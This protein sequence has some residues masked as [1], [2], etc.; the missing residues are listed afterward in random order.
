[1]TLGAF[2]LVNVFFYSA[3]RLVEIR[4][5]QKQAD[6]AQKLDG[7]IM[8]EVTRLGMAYQRLHMRHF[9]MTGEIYGEP[10]PVSSRPPQ[11]FDA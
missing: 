7:K 3:G 10:D 5:F 11:G 1:M 8:L 6:E 4:H 2:A 9:K